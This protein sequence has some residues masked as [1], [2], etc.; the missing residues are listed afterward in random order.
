LNI[1]LI[2]F[3]SFLYTGYRKEEKGVRLYSSYFVEKWEIDGK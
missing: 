3:T 2:H 1:L